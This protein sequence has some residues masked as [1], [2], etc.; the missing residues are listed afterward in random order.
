MNTA[1]LKLELEIA[2]RYVRS[3]RKYKPKSSTASAAVTASGTASGT[4][5]ARS[6]LAGDA[7][8]SAAGLTA[9]PSN[10]F[11]SFISMLSMLGIALGVAALIVV[12]SV[13]NGFGKEVRARMLSVISH[14]EAIDA[15]GSMPNWPATLAAVKQNPQVIGAAPYVSG[16]GMMIRGE[17]M[18]GVALRGVDPMLEPQVSDLAKL[19]KGAALTDLKPGAFGVFLGG[20]LANALGVQAGD[21]VNI[22][23]PS[24]TTSPVGVLPRTRKLTVLGTFDSGHFEYDSS[25]ALLHLQDAA[26]LLGVDTAS[27]VRAKISRIE[28]APQVARQLGASLGQNTIV[29]DWSQVNRTWFAAVKVEKTMMFII[30][31]LIIAVAAFNLVSMLVMTVTEKHGQIAI[32]RT[33]GA[34]PASV[35]RIFMIQGFTVGASGLLIGLVVGV[36]V[37]LNVG[38][39]VHGIE[40]LFRVQFL[41]KEIYFISEF[42]S[43]LQLG[44]VV[45]VGLIA[46]FLALISTIYPSSR[47]AKINPVEALRYE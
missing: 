1:L 41:P 38:S 22:L 31:M 20:E 21:A 6:H 44:D 27:G 36:L 13:M 40:W 33:L 12:M 5:S 2:W 7:A 43:D 4:A 30:L 25:V 17:G 15:S 47:A 34:T 35:R 8:N 18:K 19:S 26:R 29:R 37:A 42:P 10:P 39:I 11:V 16:Q 9:K 24:S 14:I 32:L 28:D 45:W 46:L 3:A 23:V